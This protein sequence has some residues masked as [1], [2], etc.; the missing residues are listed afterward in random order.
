MPALGASDT[1]SL[2]AASCDCGEEWV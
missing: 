1:M 2:E